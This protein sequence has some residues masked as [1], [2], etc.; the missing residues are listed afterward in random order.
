MSLG[1]TRFNHALTHIYALAATV[2]ESTTAALVSKVR[3]THRS[4]KRHRGHQSLPISESPRSNVRDL[5]F[6][7]CTF[8]LQS[9]IDTRS[10]VEYPSHL[11]EQGHQYLP[12]QGVPRLD[13][14]SQRNRQFNIRR[15]IR[16]RPWLRNSHSN[17]SILRTSTPILSAD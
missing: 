1:H 6:L 11:L 13:D 2:G 4:A 8:E 5:E 9:G 7:C 15:G 17:P 12:P 10:R 14:T 3:Y 16:R